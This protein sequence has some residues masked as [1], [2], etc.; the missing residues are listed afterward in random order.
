MAAEVGIVADKALE[1]SGVARFRPV[2]HADFF[3]RR[4]IHQGVARTAVVV[5]VGALVHRVR[6]ALAAA[7]LIGNRKTGLHTV[8]V[9]GRLVRNHRHDMVRFVKERPGQFGLVRIYGS[10]VLPVGKGYR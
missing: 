8:Q 4:N 5:E 9:C 1:T 7:A 2:H 6:I 3:L 10:I